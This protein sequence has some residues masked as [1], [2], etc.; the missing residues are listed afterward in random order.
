MADTSK[1]R[2][3]F[4]GVS[5][6]LLKVVVESEQAALTKWKRLLDLYMRLIHI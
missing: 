6:S 2:W 4:P 3:N 1:D 5:I